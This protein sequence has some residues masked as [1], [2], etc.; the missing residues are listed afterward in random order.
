MLYCNSKPLNHRYEYYYVVFKLY[1]E[2]NYIGK[3]HHIIYDDWYI[4]KYFGGYMNKKLIIL[5]A[6]LI[7][8]LIF[9][10]TL[11]YKPLVSINTYIKTDIRK[12]ESITNAESGMPLVLVVGTT[13]DALRKGAWFDRRSFFS[14][15]LH[16]ESSLEGSIPKEEALTIIKKNQL[17]H[18]VSYLQLQYFNFANT[19]IKISDG[20]YWFTSN[21]NLVYENKNI[22]YV[23]INPFTKN[24]IVTSSNGN[25][26]EN[27]IYWQL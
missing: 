6:S 13:K 10:K 15:K 1:L 9:Y 17:V 19:P 25:I 8:F 12:I 26:V 4:L 24:Y 23:Y 20:P 18:T 5:I 2:V 16:V 3:Y 14:F 22:R 7:F 21:E 27:T 11:F